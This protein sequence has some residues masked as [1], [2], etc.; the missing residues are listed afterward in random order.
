MRVCRACLV[1]LV[2]LVAAEE[3]DKNDIPGLFSRLD[4]NSDGFL[5]KKEMAKWIA[6]ED[7]AM[8]SVDVEEEAG[9]ALEVFDHDK[10]E[11]LNKDEFEEAIKSMEEEDVGGRNW[12]SFSGGGCMV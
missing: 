3:K 1:T 7:A 4:A 8:S 11:A 10:D 5:S 12:S 2:L 6:K 9:V